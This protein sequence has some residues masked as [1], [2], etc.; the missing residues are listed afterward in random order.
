VFQKSNLDQVSLWLPYL[1]ELQPA[2][3]ILVCEEYTDDNGMV[4]TVAS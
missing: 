1:N 4:V 3:Q 2:V